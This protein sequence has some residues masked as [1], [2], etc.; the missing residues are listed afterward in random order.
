MKSYLLPLLCILCTVMSVHAQC[1]GSP[2]TLST[3]TQINNFPS[4]YPGCSVVNVSVTIQGNTITNLNGLSSITSITKSLFL[5]NN[6]AL[7]SLSGLSNLSNIGV[8][9]TL[10]NNDA[11]T[12]LTGLENLPFIGGTLTITG[13]AALANLNALN[14]LDHINGSLLVSFNPTLTDLSGLDNVEFTGRFLQINNNNNLTAINSLNSLTEVGNNVSTNGRYLSI[15]SNQNLLTLNGFANL[16]S[17]GTDFEITNNGNLVTL[18]AFGNLATVGGEFAISNNPDLTSVAD[19]ASLSSIA[20]GLTISNNNVLTDCASQGI[21]DYLAG[22]GSATI[23]NNDP[24]CN[25]VAQVET[26]CLSLPV[27]LTDF[28]GTTENEGVTLNWTTAS[29]KNN[30]R[31][32][33]EHSAHDTRHFQVIGKVAGHGTTFSENRYELFHLQPQPGANYYRLK[34][35]DFDEKYEYSNIIGVFI[36]SDQV[37]VDIFPNPTTGALLIKGAALAGTA[38]L[39]DI[40]GSLILTQTLGENNLLDLTDQPNGMYLLEIQTESQKTLTRIIKE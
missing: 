14:N 13:N 19:F 26:A 10:D 12:D 27:K 30:A 23:S 11:L 22:P 34:Q 35:V 2:I 7:T 6:P 38:R 20:N 15:T 29:E 37:A 1:P 16:E 9:L 36:N 25:S 5:F 8:E 40:T 21:C 39:T 31:F 33:V 18:D 32:E 28:E 3:Q 17:V 24:G 4:T